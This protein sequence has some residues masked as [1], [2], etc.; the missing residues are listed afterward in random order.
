[1]RSRADTIF[2]AHS[3]CPVALGGSI[4][5]AA[6]PSRFLAHISVH[7]SR[8][9]FVTVFSLLLEDYLQN[10]P[11][12]FGGSYVASK[13][14]MG[15][16]FGDSYSYARPRLERQGG[17]RASEAS[18]VNMIKCDHGEEEQAR[19]MCHLP[20]CACL[21]PAAHIKSK[22]CPRWRCSAYRIP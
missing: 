15:R 2:I 9:T 18:S 13:I 14:E 12:K 8:N 11:C 10:P 1:M 16:A 22:S 3:P 21:P 7:E 19:I 17:K 5:S 4:F 20:S 6:A